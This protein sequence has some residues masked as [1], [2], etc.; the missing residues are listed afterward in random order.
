MEKQKQ[1]ELGRNSGLTSFSIRPRWKTVD[2]DSA[3]QLPTETNGKNTHE[4][5]LDK[6][7]RSWS[8]QQSAPDLR[9]FPRSESLILNHK[10]A[11]L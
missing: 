4:Y 1:N 8:G 6:T 7:Y 11:T 5:M 2:I 9:H 10:T 3:A